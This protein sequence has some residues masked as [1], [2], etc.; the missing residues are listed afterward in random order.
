MENVSISANECRNLAELIEL[1]VLG[2]NTLG[3][4]DVNDLELDV[5]RFGNSANG[6]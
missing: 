2:R 3:G 5:V 1:E 6:R 4:L